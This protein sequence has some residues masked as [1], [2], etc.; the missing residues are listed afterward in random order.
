MLG[1]FLAFID[2]LIFNS[3]KVSSQFK[4]VSQLNVELFDTLRAYAC[5]ENESMENL[6]SFRNEYKVGQF[7][8]YIDF[9]LETCFFHF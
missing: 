8:T 4:C 1:I 6:R 2:K 7:L 9:V 3:N 5:S